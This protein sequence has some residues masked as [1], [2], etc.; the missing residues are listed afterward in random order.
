MEPNK[1]DD[2]DVLTVMVDGGKQLCEYA[3][4]QWM[5]GKYGF[6]VGSETF[7]DNYQR[8][9]N[10]ESQISYLSRR[11]KEALKKGLL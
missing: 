10:I 6:P 4:T 2:A 9:N 7:K 8:W 3:K 5:S 11:V 1:V